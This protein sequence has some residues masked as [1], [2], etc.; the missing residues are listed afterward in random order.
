M[1]ISNVIEG[2]LCCLCS[3]PMSDGDA[4]EYMVSKSRLSTV[5]Q[6]LLQACGREALQELGTWRS[7]AEISHASLEAVGGRSVIDGGDSSRTGDGP[8]TLIG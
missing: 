2:Q 5:C 1:I 8:P 4:E 3:G 7:P 6:L